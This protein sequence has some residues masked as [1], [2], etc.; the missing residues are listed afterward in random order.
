MSESIHPHADA[1]TRS[2]CIWRHTQA[3][4][5]RGRHKMTVFAAA[6]AERYQQ[7]VPEGAR[8]VAFVR[9]EFGGF[10]GRASA[11]WNQL[12]RMMDPEIDCT[13]MPCDLEEAWV[14]CLAE[15]F[16]AA[17][18][19][20]LAARYGLLP[21]PIP[22]GGEAAADLLQTTALMREFA[23]TIEALAPI[24]ADGRIDGADVPHLPAALHDLDALLTHGAA[25]RAVMV[26]QLE[27]GNG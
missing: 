3:M 5:L 2:E 26:E 13:R 10:A 23:A 9:D 18:V 17:C 7:L 14:D 16:R 4:R 24:V 20:D 8:T 6:V 12:T 11:I 27:R 15:P 1:E 19:Q 22:R 25:L 21:V